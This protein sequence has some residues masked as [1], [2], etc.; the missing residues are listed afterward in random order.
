MTARITF[1]KRWQQSGQR[2]ARSVDIPTR[3]DMLFARGC[4]FHRR[5]AFLLSI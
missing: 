5:V 3:Q 4:P 2:A 1:L